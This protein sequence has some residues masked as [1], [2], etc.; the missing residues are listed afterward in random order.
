MT[1]RQLLLAAAGSVGVATTLTACSDAPVR[2][3]P[4]TSTGHAGVGS[5]TRHRYGARSSQFGDLYRPA[6]ASRPGVVV[7]IHGGFWLSQYDLTLGAPLAHDLA[8]RGYTAFNLEYRRV[9]NGGGWPATLTD[10]GEGIDLLAGLDVDHTH[11]VAIGHSAGGQL[12]AW[13]AGRAQRAAGSPGTDPKV[14]VTGVVS[15]AGV[16]DLATAAR[17]GVGGSAVVDF[18]GGR[19][20]QVP[21]R[22]TAA[23]PIEQVPLTAPVL[24]IHSRSDEIVPFAQSQ[25]YVVAATAAGAPARLVEVAGDHF[26]LIDP[27]SAAWQTVVRALPYLFG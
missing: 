13:A 6:G 10:V 1:R 27:H 26:T 2:R 8:T 19:P 18:L 7:I 4:R 5:T 9:G 22:Y 21:A 15:Q 14:I 24:C 16:L 3:P 20:E 11:V 23:D 17:N 25:A 12:A